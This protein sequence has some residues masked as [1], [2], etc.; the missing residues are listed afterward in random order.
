MDLKN[1]ITKLIKDNNTSQ[2]GLAEKLNLKA[3]A[4]IG[5]IQVRNDAKVSLLIKMAEV[6]DYEIVIRP[7]HGSDRAERTIILDEVNIKEDHRGGDMR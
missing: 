2:K 3:A 5:N 7:K 6:L 4:S 1:A